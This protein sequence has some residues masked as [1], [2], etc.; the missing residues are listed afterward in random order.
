M[1][2]LMQKI[3]TLFRRDF[4]N[5]PSRVLPEISP[6]CEWVLEGE[7]VA[8]RKYDG[9]SCLWSGGKLWK[10]RELKASQPHPDGFVEAARDEETGKVVG[11]VPV[12]EGPEDKWHRAAL[13]AGSDELNE[14]ATYELLGPK[15]QGG[16]EREF[17]SPT[18]LRHAEAKVMQDAP[19]TFDGLREWLA[20][21]D[22]EGLVFHHPDGRMAKIKLRDFGLRRG[23]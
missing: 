8:T 5:D 2:H 6:G 14:G 3:P 17:A 9:T 23:R 21:K 18:L 13:S 19:R 12:G 22:I 7:G 1:E 10:R 4:A 11:W 15:I 20:G 16:I